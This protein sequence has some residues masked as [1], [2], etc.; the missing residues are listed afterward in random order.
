MLSCSLLAQP[1]SADAVVV[2]ATVAWRRLLCGSLAERFGLSGVDWTG[3]GTCRLLYAAAGSLPIESLRVRRVLGGE[4]VSI[5]FGED[6]D[7]DPGVYE[8]EVNGLTCG[9]L[10][11]L[12]TAK[13]VIVDVRASG[14]T[15]LTRVRAE[16]PI[17]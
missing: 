12:P 3:V 8:V 13:R 2:G 6:V 9:A 5:A 7:L 16:T 4:W 11:A 14:S 10:L 15:C 17:D 1:F